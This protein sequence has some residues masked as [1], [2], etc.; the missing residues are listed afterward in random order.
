MSGLVRVNFPCSEN[1]G[2]TRHAISSMENARLIA[3][4]VFEKDMIVLLSSH[5]KRTERY[6]Q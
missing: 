1:A 2:V 6:L 4:I 5:N 3:D